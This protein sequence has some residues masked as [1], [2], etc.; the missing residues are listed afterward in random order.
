MAF[1][2]LEPRLSLALADASPHRLQTTAGAK[3]KDAPAGW[4]GRLHVR[5]GL[6]YRA[7]CKTVRFVAAAVS[8]EGSCASLSLDPPMSSC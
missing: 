7:R 8:V 6:H 4:P 1:A 5:A 2:A 3:Q